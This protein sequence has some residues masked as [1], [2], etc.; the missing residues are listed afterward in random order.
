MVSLCITSNLRTAHELCNKS[1]GTELQSNC[2]VNLSMP[3]LKDKICT[4]RSLGGSVG[5]M[6]ESTLTGTS[7]GAASQPSFLQAVPSAP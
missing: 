6:I 5:V 3:L 4:A 2:H 7:S 1:A